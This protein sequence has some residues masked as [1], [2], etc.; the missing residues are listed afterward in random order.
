MK[1]EGGLQEVEMVEQKEA[2]LEAGTWV[3]AARETAHWAGVLRVG[4]QG[5]RVKRVVSVPTV[6]M[7]ASQV[8][9]VATEVGPQEAGPP[10]G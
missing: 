5:G 9:W 10:E 6:A 7:V 8:D 2:R 4:H 1:E 3:E